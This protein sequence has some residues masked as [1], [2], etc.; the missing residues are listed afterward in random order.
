MF[1]FSTI[2]VSVLLLEGLMALQYHWYMFSIFPSS[3]PL[4]PLQDC[5]IACL[6]LSMCENADLGTSTNIYLS[7]LFCVCVCVC[8]YYF[9][10]FNFSL[11]F[12]L[13]YE[14]F[15]SQRE[16]PK[17]DHFLWVQTNVINSP[18]STRMRYKDVYSSSGGIILCEGLVLIH[19]Y[20]SLVMSLTCSTSSTSSSF[21][22]LQTFP[23]PRLYRSTLRSP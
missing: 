1:F 19:I 20:I 8:L 6:S 15:R 17:A 14:D 5:F 9:C 12:V 18:A 13:L 16:A 4:I 22:S 7:I 23:N 2:F 11:I 10:S 21:P 3:F